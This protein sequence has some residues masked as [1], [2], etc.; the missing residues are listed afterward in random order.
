[1]G[2]REW[3]LSAVAARNKTAMT[4]AQRERFL[5]EMGALFGAAGGTE[6]SGRI[7]AWLLICDPP[8]QTL[9]SIQNA[10]GAS[11]AS[12][13]TVTRT[14]MEVGFIERTPTAAPGARGIS[15]RVSPGAWNTLL[16]RRFEMLRRLLDLGKDASQ[17]L[18]GAPP[19]A[20]ERVE[21]MIEFHSFVLGEL[22]G[23]AKRWRRRQ[24]VT[25]R[26]KRQ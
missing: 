18:S 24:R 26:T 4:T 25:T 15:F 14:L 16:E 9:T 23:T 22:E 20:R 12:V 1:M 6:I 3:G 5:G 13:S 7:L 8:E 11:K 10:V 19:E 21:Q 2:R 17:M